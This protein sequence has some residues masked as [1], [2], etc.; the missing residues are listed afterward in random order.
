MTPPEATE[1]AR[2]EQELA[3][4]G[5][6]IEMTVNNQKVKGHQWG[7]G[8]Q[9]ILVQHGWGS[10]GTAMWAIIKAL[11]EAKF[12]V[13][14]FDAPGHGDSEGKV[15]SM[16]QFADTMVAATKLLGRF[17]AV[18]THSIAAAATPLA[19]KR[20]LQTNKAVLISPR[21]DLDGFL[22]RFFEM[23]GTSIQLLDAT[24]KEWADEFGWDSVLS[25]IPSTIT[26]N[27]TEKAL[28]IHDQQDEDVPFEDGVKIHSAWMGAKLLLTEK[29]GHARIIR[30][31]YVAQSIVAFING[32]PQPEFYATSR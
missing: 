4:R 13:F 18:V 3:D 22:R 2:R 6:R 29:L 8:D 15:S 1:R 31:D 25:A 28:I 23:T 32:G 12:S 24:R 17:E 20:G 26:P 10:R 14:A 11:V 16:F 27:R 7:D 30:S 19:L 5:N 9:K 21:D